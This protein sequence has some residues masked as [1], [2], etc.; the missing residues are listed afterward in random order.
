M[1]LGELILLVQ[2][3]DT[4]LAMI[5]D[6]M[7]FLVYFHLHPSEIVNVYL[8]HS[9]DK[10]M[11]SDV[12]IDEHI[13]TEHVLFSISHLE[14]A[15]KNTQLLLENIIEGTATY[16][17]II[18]E[19]CLKLE[20]LDVETEFNQ[21][22]KCPMIGSDGISELPGMKSLFRL[23]QFGAH[24]FTIERVCQ[25][26]DL[27]FCLNDPQLT[28]MIELAKKLESEEQKDKLTPADAE[29][30]WKNV[31]ETLCLKEDA[32]PTT[33]EIFHKVAE[34]A[35]FF[36]FIK[37]KQFV[38]P[39]GEKRFRQQFELITAQLQHEEYR[40]IVL[41]HLFAAYKFITP[42]LTMSHT[43][44][45]LMSAIAVLKLPKG[46][47]Q[48]E[49]VKSNIHLIRI[50]FSHAEDI[51]E[52][53]SCELDNIWKSG[54]FHITT[55]STSKNRSLKMWLEYENCLPSPT[56]LV[57]HESDPKGQEESVTEK[58][59]S[60][61]IESFVHRLGFLDDK[62]DEKRVQSFLHLKEV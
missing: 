11:P 34:S 46:L 60:G 12:I 56:V 50:W 24:I 22:L 33:L 49:T 13:T 19:G 38:G 53:I 36:Q 42:F 44:S 9:L 55:S 8:K 37:E 52:N 27:E 58:M 54:S 20:E 30:L 6:H 61:K 16:R 28:E 17:D 32:S 5:K 3:L 48:L 29:P 14:R 41:N 43:F 15:L 7:D 40:E 23:F 1:S 2:D 35:E 57:N 10:V 47:P 51:Y 4:F 59:T 18:A 45:S 62:I 39:N 25:Q 21:I 31:H 26:Y